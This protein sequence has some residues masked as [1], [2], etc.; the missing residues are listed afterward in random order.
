M[1]LL[2]QWLQERLGVAPALQDALVLP[3]AAILLLW[4]L[5]ELALLIAWRFVHDKPRR[6]FWR[7]VSFYIMTLLGIG[8]LS[9]IWLASLQRIASILGANTGHE[10]QEVTPLLTGAIYSV[11][12]TVVLI[13]FWRL[14]QTVFRWSV[15]R[16]ECWCEASQGIRYQRAV[17][18]TPSR[19]SDSVK[20]LLRIGRA[21][22]LLLLFYFYIPLMLSFFPLTESF[23]GTLLGYV[24]SA[25]YSIGLAVFNYLPNLIYL[26]LIILAVR[27]VV[28]FIEFV[29]RAVDKGDIVL[30]G[31]DSEWAIPTYKLIRAVAVL[32]TLMISYPYL[33]GAGS[34]IFKGFSI[35]VGA[36]VTIGSTAAIGNII[37]GVVLTYTRSFRIGD[38]VQ[39]GD[40][41]GDVLEKT[42]FVTRLR[43]IKNEEVTIPN[44]VVLAGRIMNYSGAA[45]TE[46]L[47][48]HTAVGI[49]Y[50]VDWRKVHELLRLAAEKTPHVLPDPPPFVWQQELTDYSV[51]YELNVYTDDPRQMGQAYS[52]LRKNILDAFNDAGVEIMTPSVSAIRDANQ[53][54]IPAEFNPKLSDFPGFRFLYPKPPGDKNRP[55]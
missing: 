44:G 53:P 28:K 13:L 26:A 23:G 38:R 51:C 3:L 27:Y 32:F 47:V 22:V 14:I 41:A 16:L 31:F 5:R 45:R 15:C 24:G 48:L 8:A 43:T 30:P 7:Q 29:L 39:I 54:A 46:G 2:R 33:P 6:Q 9:G 1:E 36:M 25:A 18:I 10:Q 35:F 11:V 40:V 20:M 55:G 50:D 21:L 4:I 52:E 19:V 17:L 42:L 12:A 34:E 49:G 37:S